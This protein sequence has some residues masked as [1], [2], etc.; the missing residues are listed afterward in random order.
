MSRAVELVQ[1][2]PASRTKNGAD[3]R[4]AVDVVEDLF[5]LP[6]ITHVVIVAGDSDYIA[7]AQRAKRLGR[8]VVGIGVAGSTSKSLAAACDEFADYDDIP[9][10]E[11]PDVTARGKGRASV[12]PE[13]SQ[14]DAEAAQR[15][16]SKA[17][18]APEAEPD[19]DPEAEAATKPRRRRATRAASSART[20]SGKNDDSKNDDDSDGEEVSADPEAAAAALFERALRISH[21]KDDEEWLHANVVKGQMKRMDPSFNEKA[22]GHRSFG[23]FVTAHGELAEMRDLGVRAFDAI[24]AEGLS[25]VDFFLTADGFV[26]NEINTMPGF[27]PI[28]M[29]PRCWQES[30]LSYPAL[31]DEL[32]Q[33]ALARAAA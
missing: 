6:D 24:G 4:L 27:T 25:R 28:S 1:L 15:S 3:I 13:C 16:K 23:G 29:F 8:F 33:V 30:G 26:V 22:L 2:F 9:G 18:A 17:D 19:A 10:V 21:A 11:R 7:L 5:R 20:G 12:T 31:I 14:E 32:I